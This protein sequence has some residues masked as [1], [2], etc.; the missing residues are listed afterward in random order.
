MLLQ[1]TVTHIIGEEAAQAS[2]KEGERGEG[3]KGGKQGPREDTLRRRLI[4]TLETVMAIIVN[5]RNCS[6]IWE[7]EELSVHAK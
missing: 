4:I 1:P 3:E 5:Y 6:L 2:G 7:R